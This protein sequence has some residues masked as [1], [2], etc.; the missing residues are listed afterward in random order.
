[1]IASRRHRRKAAG[2]RAAHQAQ[3]HGL[4]LI[5]ARV[6]DGDAIGLHRCDRLVEEALPRVAAR[7]FE[8]HLM[9]L[10]VGRHVGIADHGRHAETIGKRAAER[11]V[12]IGIGA[13]NVMMEMR[14]AGKDELA[15]RG[16]LVQ[17]AG[18]RDRIRSAGYR[19]DHTRVRRPQRMPGGIPTHAIEETRSTLNCRLLTADWTY[20]AGGRTRT[21][22]PALMR[23]ML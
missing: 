15:A 18:E 20:G 10:R 8:R 23:R 9:R 3:E 5:V 6:R 11:R 22:D 21:A 16:E 7:D 17:Q 19:R 1:M 13:A 4:G 12:V 14:D 2:A